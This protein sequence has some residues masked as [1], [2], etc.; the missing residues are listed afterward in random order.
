VHCA[1]ALGAGVYEPAEQRLQTVSEAGL[2]AVEA[3][4]PAAHDEQVVQEEALVV[5]E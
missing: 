5:V 2:Q 4:L 3:K 1:L